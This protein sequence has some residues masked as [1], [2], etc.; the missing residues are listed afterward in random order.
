M[1]TAKRRYLKPSTFWS[2]RQDIPFGWQP[3]MVALSLSIPVLIWAVLSYG[4]FVMPKFLPTPTQVIATGIT[5]LSEGEL[6]VDITASLGRV[7]D[8]L[9][10]R[11]HHQHSSGHF[12]GDV[13]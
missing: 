8:G 4:Q 3:V 9:F 5:L 10:V 2:I 13:C 11:R 1:I 6:M 7:I 12:D